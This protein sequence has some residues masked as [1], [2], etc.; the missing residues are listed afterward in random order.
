MCHS[1]PQ[2][3]G[4]PGLPVVGW[5]TVGGDVRAAHFFGLHGLQLL[6]LLGWWLS[7]RRRLRAGHRLALVW[8]AGAGYLGFVLILFWQAL[9]GE[10]VVAPGAATVAALTALALGVVASVSAVLVHARTT[11]EA[12]PLVGERLRSAERE[13]AGV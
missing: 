7:R 5:S 8:T 6:P 13:S 2:V 3:D 1:P 12:L 10:P 4:G 11:K 9:R